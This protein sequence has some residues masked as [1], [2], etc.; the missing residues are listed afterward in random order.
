MD[1]ERGALPL[2]KLATGELDNRTAWINHWNQDPKALQTI[3]GKEN[4]NFEEEAL[5]RR[6]DDW[7]RAKQEQEI[8]LQQ[9]L[10]Q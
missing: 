1:A 5:Q 3:K 2:D 7:N 10:E 9:Q 4:P 6:I 8:L